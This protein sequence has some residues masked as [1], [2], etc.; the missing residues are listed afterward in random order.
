MTFSLLQPATWSAQ[1]SLRIWKTRKLPELKSCQLFHQLI[2]LS[3][4]SVLPPP[5]ELVPCST[6]NYGWNRALE[7]NVRSGTAEM[8]LAIR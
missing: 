6:R 7:I 5:Y 3:A 1:W 2:L 8:H 4:A